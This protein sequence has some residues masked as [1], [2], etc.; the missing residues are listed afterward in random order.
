M[1]AKGCRISAHDSTDLARIGAGLESGHHSKE[2]VHI[3]ASQPQSPKI[4]MVRSWGIR[5]VVVVPML[6]EDEAIGVIGIYRQ[7]VRLFSDKQMRLCRTSPRKRL[8]PSRMRG[9]STNC[10]GT[11]R[12]WNSRR[13]RRRYSRLLIV[14]LAHLSLSSR[15]CWKMRTQLEASYGNMYLREGDAFRSVALHGIAASLWNGGEPGALGR[16]E[17]TYRSRKS[18][19]QSSHSTRGHRRADA[20]RRNLVIQRQSA[21]RRRGHF[22]SFGCPHAQGKRTW[23]ELSCIYRQEVR[24]LPKSRSIGQ[25]LRRPGSH[26]HRE[27]A[28]A[29]RTAQRPRTSASAH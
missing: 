1:A 28:V 8:S 24:L 2:V 6:K 19:E 15:P 20:P 13:P 3:R 29:Q 27:R 5:T 9:C 11:A 12:R 22:D 26:R 16:P 14:H 23:L 17:P 10:A 4:R 18:L 25:E 7:E 21:G